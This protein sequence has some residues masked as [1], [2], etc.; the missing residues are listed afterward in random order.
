MPTVLLTAFKPYDHWTSNASWLCVEQ[1]TRDFPAHVRLTTRLYPVDF[2]E[3]RARVAE[4]LAANYD[5]AIHL[6]Q[7]PGGTRVQLEQIAVNVG[8]RADQKPEQFGPL[9]VDGPAAY[10]TRLPLGD[11]ASTMRTAG[12]PAEI[13]FHAGT[14]LCNAVYYWS[15]HFAEQQQLR[16]RSVMI[17]LPLDPRQ[18]CELREPQ[19]SLP[20]STCAQALRFI[21]DALPVAV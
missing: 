11:W 6:G 7:A 5:L 12:I 8:G 18:V 20:A 13:S 17:H 1:L 14:Y 10:R 3:V 15:Q 16:T 21:L 4:D 2:H 9:E 19:A